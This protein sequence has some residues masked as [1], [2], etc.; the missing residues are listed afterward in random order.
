MN[1]CTYQVNPHK[2]KKYSLDDVDTSDRTNTAAAFAFLQEIEARKAKEAEAESDEPMDTSGKIVF[3]TR[4]RS[5]QDGVPTFNQSAHLKS[6]LEPAESDAAD[7]VEKSVLKGSKVQM[8]EYIIG[9][10]PA[11]DKKRKD[12]PAK[13]SNKASG[14]ALKLDHLLDQDDA[15]EEE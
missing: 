10:K 12:R 15:D 13:D 3:N 11:G 2:W 5:N 1:Y 6:A 8:P 7:N 4:K 9:K 14:A